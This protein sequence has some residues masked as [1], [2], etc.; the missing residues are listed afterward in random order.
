MDMVKAMVELLRA[1]QGRFDYYHFISDSCLPIRPCSALES[2]LRASA[3]L[4]FLNVPKSSQWVTLHRSAV[5]FLV[6]DSMYAAFG[7][8]QGS[9]CRVSKKEHHGAPDEFA[10][11]DAAL[12]HRFN[13]SRYTL[14]YVNWTKTYG[15]GR[16]KAFSKE[17][18]QA[19]I[20]E[21]RYACP[22]CFFARKFV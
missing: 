4:S 18:W 13:I 9:D 11:S 15:T 12:T 10:F 8:Q 7:C 14:T 16:P 22:R 21:S 19:G 6:D 5:P 20:R 1:A 3:P 2:H 17:S